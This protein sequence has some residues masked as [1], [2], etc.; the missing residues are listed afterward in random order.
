[1]E[2]APDRVR[3][4]EDRREALPPP[5]SKTHMSC[6]PMASNRSRN[7]PRTGCGWV[8]HSARLK[9]ARVYAGNMDLLN[10]PLI[11]R[12]SRLICLIPARTARDDLHILQNRSAAAE[13]NRFA[14]S[15]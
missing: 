6:Y 5:V 11:A 10:I 13:A 12:C 3:V 2:S 15:Y 9:P 7:E 1:M 8:S 14:G 4:R